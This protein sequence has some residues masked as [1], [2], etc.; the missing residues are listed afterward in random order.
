MKIQFSP[1]VKEKLFVKHNVVEKEVFECF[2][3]R[4]G[5]YLKDTREKLAATLPI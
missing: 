2:A 4:E 5:H 1:A 3:N